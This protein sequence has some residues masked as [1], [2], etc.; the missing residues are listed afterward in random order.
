MVKGS[1]AISTPFKLAFLLSISLSLSLPCPDSSHLFLSTSNKTTTTA[2]ASPRE[3]AAHLLSLLGTKEQASAVNAKEA[4]DY[5]SCLRFL[6]PFSPASH[7][8]STAGGR[9]LLEERRRSPDEMVWWP[10]LPVME[11]ARL[12]VDSGGEVGAVH[13]ALDPT[14]IPVGHLFRICYSSTLYTSDSSWGRNVDFFSGFTGKISSLVV[15]I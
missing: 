6:V 9:G 13:R 12:A 3:A 8:V 2:A 11:L 7:R 10:P 15:D 5:R 4:R 1:S 14:E